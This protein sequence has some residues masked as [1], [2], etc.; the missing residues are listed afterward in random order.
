MGGDRAE[1]AAA[2]VSLLRPRVIAIEIAGIRRLERERAWRDEVSL[3]VTPGDIF[4]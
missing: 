2:F 1:H 4:D 3:T